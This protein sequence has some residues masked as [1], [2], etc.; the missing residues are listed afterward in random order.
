MISSTK[1]LR[2]NQKG[3][4]Q[5]PATPEELEEALKNF[6][7]DIVNA[8]ADLDVEIEAMRLA[9]FE[10]GA[11]PVNRLNDLRSKARA[12]SRESFRKRWVEKI[13]H[14]HELR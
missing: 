13:R 12:D 9:V 10:T 4:P 6:R 8:L 11:I 7:D 3:I 14:A 1:E 2:Q 5:M